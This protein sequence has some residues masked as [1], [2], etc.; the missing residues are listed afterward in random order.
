MWHRVP[1]SAQGTGFGT[2][3]G[4]GYRVRR[5]Q[6]S[7]SCEGAEKAAQVPTAHFKTLLGSATPRP[8]GELG[9]PAGE[10]KTL[11]SLDSSASEC[12]VS[13][14]SAPGAT[15]SETAALGPAASSP[16]QP[17]PPHDRQEKE[18]K[19][20][21]SKPPRGG[22]AGSGAGIFRGKVLQE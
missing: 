17:K 7:P 3:F 10:T 5:V 18:G 2:G 6:L 11:P 15:P 12:M 19:P 13:G 1:G 16:A 21:K 9:R 20:L 22:R 8:S 4:T 14:Q